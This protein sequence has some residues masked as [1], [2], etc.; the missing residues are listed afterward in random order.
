MV[1]FRSLVN[2][3]LNP[4]RRSVLSSDPFDNFNE[5]LR[6]EAKCVAIG[7]K[8]LFDGGVLWNDFP[9]SWMSWRSLTSTMK[10]DRP[11][12]TF[13]RITTF[14][15]RLSIIDLSL[16]VLTNPVLIPHDSLAFEMLGPGKKRFVDLVKLARSV[17]VPIWGVS[18][19]T[20]IK[21]GC[22]R[23][24]Q[25]M[26]P[27][28]PDRCRRSNIG[29]Q[30]PVLEG[31]ICSIGRM[32]TKPIRIALLALASST[33]F[34]G[35]YLI[36]T[37]LYL[38][39]Y[40]ATRFARV[41]HGNAQLIQDDNALL[42][43]VAERVLSD[44]TRRRISILILLSLLT[45]IIQVIIGIIFVEWRKQDC[46]DMLQKLCEEQTKKWRIN[47]KEEYSDIHREL[48]VIES[49]ESN[50]RIPDLSAT[51]R[52]YQRDT[53]TSRFNIITNLFKRSLSK[54]AVRNV[55]CLRYMEVSTS[56]KNRITTSVESQEED[57][58]M[59]DWTTE[60]GVYRETSEPVTSVKV[61]EDG[62]TTD[63]FSDA[64][65]PNDTDSMSDDVSS[66]RPMVMVAP[67][68]GQ[69]FSY[70]IF[71]AKFFNLTNSINN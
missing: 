20:L 65:N 32:C 10:W 60:A 42:V 26:F 39:L 13:S 27:W 29:F 36:G 17:K 71:S 6:N 5:S 54:R 70:A 31:N 23:V 40:A 66:V 34:F 61:K 46:L 44:S 50:G 51:T 49:L 18:G 7:N 47:A 12:S 58:I 35:I 3:R 14:M 8:T 53:E 30:D 1:A 52:L 64:I 62:D 19:K 15:S 57:N 59:T 69:V 4:N 48:Y 9:I 22:T 16:I 24:S 11:T 25:D 41:K 37:F 45:S 2:N 63:D 38:S 28:V 55:Y 68:N 56:Y 33:L 67:V 43:F 21:Y